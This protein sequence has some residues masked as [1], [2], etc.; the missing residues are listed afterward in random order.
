MGGSEVLV[1]GEKLGEMDNVYDWCCNAQ[2]QNALYSK[3]HTDP[4][5][6]ERPDP[7]DI[8]K[9]YDS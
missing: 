5:T 9:D 4:L 8:G 7:E 2:R 6:G 3:K 1:T